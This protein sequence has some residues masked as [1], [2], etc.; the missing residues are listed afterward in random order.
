MKQYTIEAGTGQHVGDRKEQQDRVALLTAPK[1][2]GYLLAVL[3]DG[4]G[5]SKGGVLAA[6]Q[7]I[8]TSKQLLSEFSP[9]THTVESLLKS[10]V[11]ES[12]TIINLIGITA[13]NQP[14]TT[15]VG[16]VLTPDRKA[17]WAHA[18]D[19]RLYRFNGPN[20]QEHTIDHSYVEMLIDK[21]EITREQARKHRM[22]NL[23]VNGLGGGQTPYVTIGRHN[24]LQPGDAFL[25]C[26]DG[27]WQHVNSSEL[28]ADIAANTPRQAAEVLINKARERAR[29]RGDNCTLAIIK[30][31]A[32]E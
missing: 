29:G 27:L 25:L 23:L 14:Q 7:I 32:P 16:L 3:A 13:S 26:S 31:I 22:S 9:L 28:A 19:S 4:M 10:I 6:E 15:V 2:P 8:H 30:L 17:V 1:A 5:G 24:H 18:G 20:F 12:H 11:S 21:G